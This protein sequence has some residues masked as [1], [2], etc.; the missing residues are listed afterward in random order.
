MRFLREVQKCPSPRD[1]AIALVPF[2][3]GTRIAEIAGLDVDD[4]RLSAR[5]GILRILGKG[6]RV[7]EIP[8]H[9]HLRSALTGWLD[10]RPDWPGAETRALFINQ[11]GG[12]LSVKGAHDIIR[13]SSR[14][15]GE[16]RRACPPPS[17][18]GGRRS[19]LDRLPA[20]PKPG[21]SGAKFLQ[22]GGSSCRTNRESPLDARRAAPLPDELDLRPARQ[23]LRNFQAVLS[24]LKPTVVQAL[25]EGQ[26]PFL[27]PNSTGAP[28]I[29]AIAI[30][31][32]LE[33]EEITAHVL[34]HTFATR[35]VRGRTDLVIVAELLGHARLETTRVYS[36]PTHQDAIDALELL[37][38]D[39]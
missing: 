32:G 36:R 30:A 6:E 19:G 14:L 3:A 16:G 11:R 8:I 33:N 26:G 37:D 29:T 34:R 12:R 18:A 28:I 25:L 15:V 23:N 31:A 7:R 5:K 9:P 39:H 1:R 24:A 17:S 13:A 4:V 21:S 10:E 27:T 22:L 2:Y 35:L 38:V 20:E